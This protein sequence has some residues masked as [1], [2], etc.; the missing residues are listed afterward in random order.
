MANGDSASHAGKPDFDARE[1]A[2]KSAERRENVAGADAPDTRTGWER[3]ADTVDKINRDA[4]RRDARQKDAD[5]LAARNR[6]NTTDISTYVPARILWPALGCPAVIAPGG[7]DR[8]L[9]AR[10]LCLLVL[11]NRDPAHVRLSKGDV[12]KHLR[13]VP[14]EKR[15]EK[16]FYEPGGPESFQE[17]DIEVRLLDSHDQDG[18]RHSVTDGRVE[19]VK[20]GGPVLGEPADKSC[21]VVGLSTWVRQYYAGE[22]A[23]FPL[24]KDK[25]LKYLYEVRILEHAMQRFAPAAAGGGGGGSIGLVSDAAVG[26]ASALYHVFWVN[27]GRTDNGTH[28][29]EE[30][31]HL[32]Q[33]YARPSRFG[34]DGVPPYDQTVAY[35][36]GKY[37]AEA[38]RMLSEYEFDFRK[39]V[40][41]QNRTELLHP[42]F[43]RRGGAEVR[44]GHMT[45]IHLDTRTIA[46]AERIAK[47]QDQNARLHFHDW[48]K[49]CEQLYD[50]VKKDSD[51]LLMTGDLIDY[52]RGYRGFG[53]L[54]DNTSY[55]RDRNWF[56]FYDF[57][58]SGDK[59]TVPTYTSLGNHDWRLNPYPPF[60]FGAPRP[61]DF[62]LNKQELQDA[63]GKN[64]G[65]K[66]YKAALRMLGSFIY[67]K[68]QG[69][70]RLNI[71][72]TPTETTI[73]SVAWYLLLINPFLDYAWHLP[74]GYH[75]VVLDWAIDEEVDLEVILGGESQ[76]RNAFPNT[77]GGPKAKLCPT[78]VQMDLLE[79]VGRD[80][81]KAKILAMHAPPIG[82]WGHWKD[83]DLARGRIR[84]NGN[85]LGAVIDKLGIT[86][87]RQPLLGRV[88]GAHP[89]YF[90]GTD[91][92]RAD[93]LYRLRGANYDEPLLQAV[94]D[95]VTFPAWEYPTLAIR[96]DYEPLGR[97]AD[98]G[99][100]REEGRRWMIPVLRHARFS[101]VLAGHIHRQNVLYIDSVG[102]DLP[103]EWRGKLVVRSVELDRAPSAPQPLFVN[104]TSAGPLG[105]R[106]LAHGKYMVAASGYTSVRVAAGGAISKVEFRPNVALTPRPEEPPSLELPAAT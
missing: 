68:V 53:P 75:L 9:P 95:G 99:S 83:D 35:K 60:T 18:K 26:L 6:T 62:A 27:V 17:E 102:K 3:Q 34:H 19:L 15:R 65:D 91:N 4:A 82:P 36:D 13:I 61:K 22:L 93:A 104:T 55:W 72:E 70:G 78:R 25:Q 98:Y 88:L 28:R 47:A 79:Q 80:P 94:A 41:A 58:A 40:S 105:H 14:W 84:Y 23:D 96:G 44:I 67:W 52:G 73:E 38:Q 81:S 20:I 76:G 30:M 8:A 74:G 57:L 49:A 51:V 45:D 92:E 50:E 43:V 71:P 39:P 59:Y 10:T 97:E 29:S 16:R 89:S 12:A 7:S 86:G 5:G 42:V 66:V 31:H 1:A 11:S 21:F 85:D 69:E 54:G 37:R 24:P 48:N 101:L 77:Y 90:D 64:H 2:R 33:Y 46:Y 106:E 56:L 32:L 63:Y 100:F 87:K 103:P